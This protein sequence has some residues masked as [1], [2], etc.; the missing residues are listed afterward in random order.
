MKKKEKEHPQAA[1]MRRW[2]R[3]YA[4]KAHVATKAN[5][6]H[7]AKAL[8][9]P[10]SQAPAAVYRCKEELLAQHGRLFTPQ[11]LPGKHRY[12]TA[13]AC[14]GNCLHLA[15][16]GTGLRYAEGLAV[17]A[18]AGAAGFP[19]HHAWCVDE[20]GRVLDPTWRTPGLVY[21]GVLFP[22]DTVL[23]S[24]SPVNQSVLDDWPHDWPVLRTPY[25]EPI[26]KK[27]KKR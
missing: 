1:E 4:S 12:R 9:S 19:I 2:C 6:A 14:F 17:P 20:D 22:F 26:E 21:F 10:G 11:R 25:V 23:S 16:K 8:N 27:E 18:D 13:R 3:D 24:Q 5:S 7:V 15:M